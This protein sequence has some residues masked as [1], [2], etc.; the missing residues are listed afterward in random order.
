MEKII[1]KNI[2]FLDLSKNE[3]LIL[4]YKNGL[5]VFPSGPGLSTIENDKLYLNSLIK[6][7]VF[8]QITGQKNLNSKINFKMSQK[9]SKLESIMHT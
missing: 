8:L 2:K 4:F 5:F 1:F 9:L 6:S 3:L 7:F